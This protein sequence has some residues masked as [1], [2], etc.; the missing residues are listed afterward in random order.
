MVQ[1]SHRG[2]SLAE[3]LLALTLLTIVSLVLMGL[4][5]G[6]QAGAGVNGEM[7]LASDVV[8]SQLHELKSGSFSNLEATIGT[9]ITSTVT[10]GGRDFQL[11]TEVS[12]VGTTPG[13]PDYRVLSLKTTALWTSS[14]VDPGGKNRQARL[15]LQT[16]VGISA[17]Y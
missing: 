1:N 2:F 4:L 5:T 7:L 11:E 8:E 9:P 12:R 3:L 16:Q 14:S 10:A 15:S 6:A 17:R 13:Q